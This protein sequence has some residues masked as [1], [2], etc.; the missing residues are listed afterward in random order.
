MFATR[1]QQ[2]YKHLCPPSPLSVRYFSARPGSLPGY[3]D[4]EGLK[5]ELPLAQSAFSPLRSAAW[6]GCAFSQPCCSTPD[7]QRSVD[8]EFG[9]LQDIRRGFVGKT[10]GGCQL[11]DS[12]D[13]RPGK[14]SK[15][16]HVYRGQSIFILTA[17][18]QGQQCPDRLLCSFRGIRR[19]VLAYGRV[20]HDS[21]VLRPA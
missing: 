3:D 21:K 15:L 16:T 8:D 11:G 17:L 18:D 10:F 5:L 6:L 1:A 7:W 12:V 9:K 2:F 13:H 4:G 19:S 20:E 14:K